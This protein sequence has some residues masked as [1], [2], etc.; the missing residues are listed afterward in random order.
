MDAGLTSQGSVFAEFAYAADVTKFL[1][2]KA[3]PK[4]DPEGEDMLVESKDAYV[5]RKC[6]EKGIPEDEIHKNTGGPRGKPARKFN[7]FREMEKQQ[8]GMKPDLAKIPGSVDI[9]GK[10]PEAGSSDGKRKREDDGEGNDGKREKKERP[11]VTF[12]YKGV[13]LEV[14]ETGEVK[15][16]MQVPF[17]DGA[18]VKFT[19]EGEGDWKALKE[20]VV[21]NA[22]PDVFMALPAGQK[23]GTIAKQDSSKITDD[24]LAKLNGANLKYAENP[25]QWSRMSG[26]SLVCVEDQ[27]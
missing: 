4:F 20:A 1:E 11:P 6:K 2:N 10:A 13:T 16:P 26:E 14:S 5:K 19:V 22:I 25:V 15:D 24:D 23:V 27:R 18:A 12:E 17:E 7:A 8:K 21:A 3:I 9:V